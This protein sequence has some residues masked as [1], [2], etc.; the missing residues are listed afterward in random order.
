MKVIEFILG[1]FLYIV[2]LV[3]VVFVISFVLNKDPEKVEE[4]LH[5]ALKGVVGGLLT[6]FVLITFLH[7]YGYY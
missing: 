5:W 7:Y 1:Q 6:Y 2:A 3:F 4:W